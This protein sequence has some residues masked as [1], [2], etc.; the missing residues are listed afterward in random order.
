MSLNIGELAGPAGMAPL[1]G[2]M[3]S[4]KSGKPSKPRKG[5][6]EKDEPKEAYNKGMFAKYIS[7]YQSTLLFSYTDCFIAG[8]WC[9][10]VP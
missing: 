5:E 10:K 7:Q 9:P 4:A 3:G 6:N 1:L 8:R 2:A